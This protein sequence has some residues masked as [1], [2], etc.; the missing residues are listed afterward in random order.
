MLMKETTNILLKVFWKPF[1]FVFLPQDTFTVKKF[2]SCFCNIKELNV[3]KQI[4]LE[5]KLNSIY[6]Q[7]VNIYNYFK[8][9]K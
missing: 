3:L 1:N 5:L 2:Q 4:T 9:T 6:V 7:C 8:T